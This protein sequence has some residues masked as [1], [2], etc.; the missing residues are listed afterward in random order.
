VIEDAAIYR[1]KE[2]VLYDLSKAL[3]FSPESLEA[4]RKG[5]L[6]KE[7]AKQLS[8]QCI[9]PAFLTFLF[10]VAPFLIWTWITAGR[11]QLSFVNAFPA[12]LTELTHPNDLVESHG[13]MGAALMLGS[14]VI[15]L[16]IAAFMSFRVPLALYFDLLDRKVD[17]KEGRVTA[18]EETTNRANGRDPIENYFFCLRYLTMP[19]NLAAFRALE[20]GSIYI[21][22]VTHR[23]ELLVAI[24]PKIDTGEGEPTSLTKS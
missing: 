16:A 4:N 22:Y 15:S 17:A 9:Q 8:G 19:V 24:E 2:Q 20:E 1:S 10:A 6:S 14:I 3:R 7:Q 21:V 23:S 11:E 5:Q 18:R 12:L 13:K